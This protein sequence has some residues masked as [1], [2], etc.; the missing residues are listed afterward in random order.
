[1][2]LYTGGTP[3]IMTN[4]EYKKLNVENLL[5]KDR[6]RNYYGDLAALQ[7]SIELHGIVDPLIVSRDERLEGKY[8]IIN[9]GRRYECAKL[10]GMEEVPCVIHDTLP[11]DKRREVELELLIK[12]KSLE[13]DEEAM[14]MKQIVD[15]RMS[16]KHVGTLGVLGS[17]MRK[18]DIAKELGVSPSTLSQNLTI[19]EHLLLYPSLRDKCK[20]RRQAMQKIYSGVLDL[21]PTEDNTEVIKYEEYLSLDSPLDLVKS[22]DSRIVNLFILHPTEFDKELLTECH[23]RLKVGGAMV[24]FTEIDQIPIY[25][26]YLK[27]SKLHFHEKPYLWNITSTGEYMCYL[28]CGKDRENPLRDMQPI[29]TYSGEI[30]STHIKAKSRKLLSKIIRCNTDSGEIVVIPECWELESINACIEAHVNVRAA[31][32]DSSVR[33]KLIL[34]EREKAYKL[35]EERNEDGF[36]HGF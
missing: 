9:G 16:R 1:M 32:P 4:P 21:P 15:R 19:A 33:D 3:T 17:N 12:Q 30:K 18:K 13:W 25:N 7:T 27:N 34:T 22:I 36:T 14:A 29:M 28:W 31:C 10:L 20:S 23:K 11:E 6:L 24:I 5:S 8:N 26:I 35:K 2:P